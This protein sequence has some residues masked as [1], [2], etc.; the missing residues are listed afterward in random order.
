VETAETLSFI[1]S[2]TLRLRPSD[3]HPWE[4]R[5]G[6]VRACPCCIR[7]PSAP[8][9]LRGA[10]M[11]DGPWGRRSVWRSG[12]GGCMAVPNVLAAWDY[13]SGRSGLG[14]G[15][16][17][18]TPHDTRLSLTAMPGSP[19]A[20]TTG[21]PAGGDSSSRTVGEAAGCGCVR[22]QARLVTAALGP[23]RPRSVAALRCCAVHQLGPGM[24]VSPLTCTCIWAGA[25]LPVSRPTAWLTAVRRPSRIHGTRSTL[26]PRDQPQHAF[27]RLAV[28]LG[29]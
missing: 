24:R 7:L 18:P 19:A 9:P 25:V 14:S 21:T 12:G 4:E 11:R 3:C 8:H 2:A 17:D 15:Q 22:A 16:A 26:A 5:S 10:T 28:R 27:G 23:V 13:E 6:Q 29:H 1:H 20:T